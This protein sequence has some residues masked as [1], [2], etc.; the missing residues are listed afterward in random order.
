MGVTHLYAFIK[1]HTQY[2]FVCKSYLKFNQRLLNCLASSQ[3]H[4]SFQLL[5]QSLHL[6]RFLR[7]MIPEN[8]KIM[9]FRNGDMDTSFSRPIVIVLHT[10]PVRLHV[11]FLCLNVRLAIPF[12]YIPDHCIIIRKV[13][14]KENFIYNSLPLGRTV[15]FLHIGSSFHYV[16]I[17]VAGSPGFVQSGYPRQPL[18]LRP[19]MT[20]R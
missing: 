1:Q 3:N 4:L 12:F 18:L 9:L 15:I 7:E 2:F 11:R 6:L 8:V 10:T 19:A 13:I 17:P 20:E 16:S 14:R 5:Q